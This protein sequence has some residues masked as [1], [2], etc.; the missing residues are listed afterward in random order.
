MKKPRASMVF[1][2]SGCALAAVFLGLHLGGLREH[3]TVLSGNLAGTS[4][5]LAVVYIVSWFAFVLGTPILLIAA[6]V[7]RVMEKWFR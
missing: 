3:T 5:T 7:Q 4:P 6:G 2:V 1:F